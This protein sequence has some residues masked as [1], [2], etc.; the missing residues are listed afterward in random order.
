MWYNPLARM[1]LASSDRQTQIFIEELVRLTILGHDPERCARDM[2][3]DIAAIIAL[4]GRPEFDESFRLL[5]PAK[6]QAWV[7]ARQAQLANQRVRTLARNDAVEHY[8]MLR[9][10]VRKSTEMREAERAQLL[11]RLIKMSGL[12]DDEAHE[13]IVHLAP[14]QI[15]NINVA[16]NEVM[17]ARTP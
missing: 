9:D 3:L 7:E 16:Y 11:E 4:I 15:A 1:G 5:A 2:D 6:H 17:G 8:L 12:L 13:E 10:Q 14:S